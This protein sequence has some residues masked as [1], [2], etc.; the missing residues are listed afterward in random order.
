MYIKVINPGC[1]IAARNRGVVYEG[2]YT[3]ANVVQKTNP[4]IN[5]KT[6]LEP[7]QLV[8]LGPNDWPKNM[9]GLQLPKKNTKQIESIKFIFI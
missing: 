4:V 8:Q 9:H 6:N 3:Y 1:E 2:P 5:N 7:N